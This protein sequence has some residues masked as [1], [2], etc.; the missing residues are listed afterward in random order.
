MQYLS[1]R[2]NGE[3]LV[4]DPDKHIKM[5]ATV[6]GDTFTVEPVFVDE[7]RN[8][9]GGDHAAVRPR[10][11]LVSGPAIQTGKYTFRIDPDYFGTDPERLWSGITICVEAD[12][13]AFFK[14]AVQELNLQV[15]K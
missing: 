15:R 4:Y 3:M 1:A 6:Q 9:P 14:P 5:N 13:D 12:G 11:V 2:V 8:A 7:T 10:V